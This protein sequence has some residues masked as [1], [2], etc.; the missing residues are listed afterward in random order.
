[1]DALGNKVDSELSKVTSRMDEM[2]KH[3][4]NQLDTLA[5]KMDRI[6]NT[7]AAMDEGRS[8]DG[9][10]AAVNANGY[11]VRL[12]IAQQHEVDATAKEMRDAKRRENVLAKMAK[13][14][15]F[16]VTQKDQEALSMI[17]KRKYIMLRKG[18][19]MPTGAFRQVWDMVFIFA[20]MYIVWLLPYR[21]A[22]ATGHSVEFAVLD[23]LLDLFFMSDILLNFFTAYHDAETLLM[24]TNHKMIAKHYAKT[25]LLPDVLS[26]IPYDWLIVGLSFSAPAVGDESDDN[27]FVQLP[28]LLR[29]IKCVKLLRLLRVTRAGRY[30]QKGLEK[31]QLEVVLNSNVLRL[32]GVGAFM[33]LFAHWNSC[34]QYLLSTFEADITFV[35]G[36]AT[37]TFQSNSWVERM[38]ADG[39]LPRDYSGSQMWTWCFYGS[40]MQMLA[41]S[42]GL[43]EP[44]RVSEM[45]GALFSLLC[46]AVIYGYFLASL[47]TAIAESDQSAKEYR[48]KLN[49]MNEY[50]KYA[51]V[52]K[53]LRDH[54]RSYYELF[55]P[56]K[57]AFDEHAILDELSRPLKS[58]V[59]LYKCRAVL[60]ALQL[61]SADNV[62]EKNG[63][64][65]AIS[66][67]LDRVLF[68]NGDF[69]IRAGDEAEG[70]YFISKGFAEV[71]NKN[72]KL[73]TTLGRGP[74]LRGLDAPRRW[75]SPLALPSPSPAPLRSPSRG[76]RL[77]TV[78]SFFGEMA[79]LEPGKRATA[80]VRV[81]SFCD[82]FFISLHAFS[83]LT[84]MYPSF[85]SYLQSVAKLRQGD[86][87]KRSGTGSIKS[88][89][90]SV[91]AFNKVGLGGAA[92]KERKS[93]RFS[94]D[95]G[96][97][98]RKSG[99]FESPAGTR[100]R[101]E[102][103]PKGEDTR[104]E[105]T[106]TTA[107]SSKIGIAQV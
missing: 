12:S 38:L 82:T 55:F 95:G 79:L 88:A 21:I 30:I 6:M 18:I 4:E 98:S 78:G 35:N 26:S 29:V 72:G 100:S 68:V 39:T 84:G 51:R 25:W 14:E 10:R 103:D 44:E 107:T 90:Q 32:L 36:T 31:A 1:M 67:H 28:Q 81:S 41:I 99:R 20:I 73:V 58:Q 101:G 8:A 43:K 11:N 37:Y 9:G 16:G 89:I 85:K 50:M 42:E 3:H 33:T 48:K 49:M 13:E 34:F 17:K 92:G 97:S 19:L 69:V 65:E 70:M 5:A 105:T 75:V 66:L 64:M 59:A 46:G 7:L 52:P 93:G 77:L 2:G 76:S 94:C 53:K 57:R 54:M 60:D 62:A 86:M 104:T 47:T 15:V 22:F 24:V 63:L 27:D 83:K 71:L 74:M 40:W 91:K 61:I 80:S 102:R 87:L 106:T 45:W 23:F 56:A 96:C